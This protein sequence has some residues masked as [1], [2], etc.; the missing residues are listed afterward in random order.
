MFNEGTV[1]DAILMTLLR[2]EEVGK[3]CLERKVWST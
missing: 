2:N 3:R 1:H